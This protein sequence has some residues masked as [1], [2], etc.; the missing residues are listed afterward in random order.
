MPL[1]K[2]TPF[3]CFCAVIVTDSTPPNTRI[4]ILINLPK[5]QELT[6]TL[7]INLCDNIISFKL[8]RYEIIVVVKSMIIKVKC[9]HLNLML[10]GN[11]MSDFPTAHEPE[12]DHVT[13]T[14]QRPAAAAG[15]VDRHMNRVG[16]VFRD[17][18]TLMWDSQS[19]ASMPINL[20][21]QLC[22][23]SFNVLEI[24]LGNTTRK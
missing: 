9:D 8:Y 7:Q 13:I 10:L 17:K 20:M 16:Q 15:D 11:Q 1:N 12:Q 14:A 3:V 21:Q 6:K 5:N 4:L 24:G 18:L 22:K 2:M 23:K 19:G